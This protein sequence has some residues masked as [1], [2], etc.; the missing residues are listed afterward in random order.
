MRGLRSKVASA[1]SSLVIIMSARPK[2]PK[3]VIK[4]FFNTSFLSSV[5]TSSSVTST[6]FRKRVSARTFAAASFLAQAS[7]KSRKAS[8]LA[9][10]P[11]SVSPCASP[12]LIGPPSYCRYSS[13][14]S[15]D[16]R[17]CSYHDIN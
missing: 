2:S 12:I 13:S 11:G 14:K 8:L 4:S 1:S 9:V 3:R 5:A 7:L 16:G 17:Y 6:A 15:G 10:A